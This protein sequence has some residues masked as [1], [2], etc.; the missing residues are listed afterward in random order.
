STTGLTVAL[1]IYVLSSSPYRSPSLLAPPAD[2]GPVALAAAVQGFWLF[3]GYGTP[4]FYSEE[5]ERPLSDVWK[6]IAAATALSAAVYLLSV[7]AI[8]SAVP[9]ADLNVL[10]NSP[11]PYIDAWSKYLPQWALLLYPLALAPAVLAYGGPAGSHARLLWAMARDGFIGHKKLREVKAGVPKNAALFNLAL[12]AATALGT[13]ALTF[14]LY[15]MSPAAAEE[16]W[17][18]VSTA[19]TV[20]W[21][22]HHVPPELALYPL[23]RKRPGL[24]KSRAEAVLTGVLAP[25][26]G[27]AIFLYTLYYTAVYRSYLPAVC[28]SLAVAV[29]ALVYT[30]IKRARGTLGS[31]TAAYLLAERGGQL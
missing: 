14:A 20:L 21:Y 22:F 13:S 11:M 6:A 31:S 28:A 27:L 24:V 26:A 9:P 8:V 4:L 1:D 29:A 5:A 25:A 7:Y 23:L 12:S 19:A 30:L 10:A 18:E 2:W 3:V 17:L 16:A 15:G